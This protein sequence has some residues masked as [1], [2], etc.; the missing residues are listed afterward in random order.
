M[1][2]RLVRLG[3]GLLVLG[4][5]AEEPALAGVRGRVLRRSRFE[6]EAGGRVR[7]FEDRDVVGDFEELRPVE[8]RP[9][10]R[11]VGPVDGR[12]EVEGRPVKRGEVA[13]GTA[14]DGERVEPLRLDRLGWPAE[15]PDV[16]FDCR[17]GLVDEE[18]RDDEDRDEEG[19][20]AEGRDAEDRDAEGRDEEGRDEEDGR[21]VRDGLFERLGA[22]D[23]VD[24]FGGSLDSARFGARTRARQARQAPR[25]FA[26]R[27]LL[28]E[29][30]ILWILCL[31]VMIASFR[32][33][34]PTR[35]VFS[36]SCCAHTVPI[37]IG[38]RS[39]RWSGVV[40]CYLNGVMETLDSCLIPETAVLH[41]ANMS[42]K[43]YRKSLSAV[44]V[45][46]PLVVS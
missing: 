6:L 1:L 5:F 15:R 33:W 42:S 19:R 40:K 18:D 34:W 45:S 43:G 3:R 29:T 22:L 27:I 23:A 8:L 17:G 11:N 21:E 24:C 12:D 37:A 4:S 35:F 9:G 31:R 32:S 44:R 25:R 46:F 41:V 38:E 2:S 7:P 26:F 14:R 16:A 20:D 10:M 13:D 30:L 39:L 28:L 36:V